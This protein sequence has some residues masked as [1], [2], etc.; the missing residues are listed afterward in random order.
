VDKE[1]TE[2]RMLGLQRVVATITAKLAKLPEV[3]TKHAELMRNIEVNERLVEMLLTDLEEAKIQNKREIQAAVL[4]DA[5]TPP[6]IR[7]S[8]SCG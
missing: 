1:V 6:R 3:K 7:S 4:V 8:R 2:A 5:A